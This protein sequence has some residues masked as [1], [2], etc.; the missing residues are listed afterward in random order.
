MFNFN[1]LGKDWYEFGWH[2]LGIGG[3]VIY[4]F[5]FLKLGFDFYK[6]GADEN[7]EK[8][9]EMKKKDVKTDNEKKED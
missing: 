4:L 5:R 3:I 2:C 6:L 9:T 1:I 8:I 7:T